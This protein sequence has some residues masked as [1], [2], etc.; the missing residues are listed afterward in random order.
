MDWSSG[1]PYT[2][3]FGPNFPGCHPITCQGR[4]IRRWESLL[5]SCVPL[6]WHAALACTLWY[7]VDC[8]GIV[9]LWVVFSPRH[10]NTAA[11]TGCL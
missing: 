7:T 5:G 1:G 11:R 6:A 10:E 3:L 4:P 9:T 2:C 8:E